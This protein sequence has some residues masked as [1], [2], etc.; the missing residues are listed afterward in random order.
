[1]L[2]VV[3]NIYN[4]LLNYLH[5]DISFVSS[6][7]AMPREKQGQGAPSMKLITELP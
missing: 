1:M 6:E 5:P 3:K 7:T 2:K 4:L